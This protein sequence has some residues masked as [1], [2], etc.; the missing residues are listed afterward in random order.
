MDHRANFD[1]RFEIVTIQV[2]VIVKLV[3]RGIKRQSVVMIEEGG[4]RTERNRMPVFFIIVGDPVKDPMAALD[5]DDAEAEAEDV[6]K[7]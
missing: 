2:R 1:I 5:N 3:V 6:P 7:V 4:G